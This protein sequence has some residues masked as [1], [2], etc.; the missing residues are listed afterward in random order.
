MAAVAILNFSEYGQL[1]T[2]FDQVW[3]FTHGAHTLF[4]Y[5]KSELFPPVSKVATAAIL[6]FIDN[7]HI[8]ASFQP[9]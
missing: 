7:W 2:D 4:K 1:R 8:S 9:F 3:I 5:A 6:N